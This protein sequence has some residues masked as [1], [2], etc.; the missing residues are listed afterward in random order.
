M[1]YV[2]TLISIYLLVI[3]V[4]LIVTGLSNEV[5]KLLVLILI[6]GN[7]IIPTINVLFGLELQT[8]MQIGLYLSYFILGDYFARVELKGKYRYLMI[9][10]FTSLFRAVS[11]YWW[12]TGKQE[13][14]NVVHNGRFFG[15]VQA[16]SIFCFF[17]TF[18]VEDKNIP[19]I[20]ERISRA[21]FGI[22]LIHPVFGNVFYK[23]LNLTPL[24]IPVPTSLGVIVCALLIFGL[25]WLATEIMIRIPILRK[26]L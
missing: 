16:V 6:T 25:S 10:I 9:F 23:I 13:V 5:Y 22:Y 4:R 26:I 19:A 7:F 11:D 3:P 1:W 17:R 20:I 15:L 2:Y 14:L 24:T 18:T 21:S 12:I 8:Y